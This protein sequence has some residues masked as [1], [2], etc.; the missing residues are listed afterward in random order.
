DATINPDFGQVEVDP[1]VVNL[2][3][4]ETFFSE[5]RPFFIEGQSVFSFGRGGSNN[6]WGFNWGNPNFFH[7]RRIGRAP[8]GHTPSS[9]YSHAPDGTRI[10]GAAKLTGKIGEGWNFGAIQAVTNHA[11]ADYSI[12]GEIMD[13]EVEPL[14]YYG[15]ARGQREF[16]EGKRAIGF[17]GT[18]TARQFDNDDL[19]SQINGSAFTG[20]VDGWTFLDQDRTW[21]VTGWVGGTHIKGTQERILSVQQNPQHYF[22]RP[23]FDFI[24]VDSTATS[25]SGFAGRAMLNKQRGKFSLNSAVGLI[26][27]SFDANDLGFQFQTNV[28]NAHVVG[29][30]RWTEPKGI[31]RRISVNSALFNSWDFDGNPTWRGWFTN[32]S[33]TFKNYYSLFVGGAVNPSSIS[34]RRSRGGPLMKNLP[35][36]EVFGGIESDSR[37]RLVVELFGFT[38]QTASG[39][40]MNVSTELEWKPAPNISLEIEP[41]YGRSSSKAQWI[42]AFD[43]ATDL[44]TFGRRYVFAELS[45]TTVSSNIRLNWT[46]SPSLSLQLFAQ[47]LIASGEYTNFK[48]LERPKS[49]DFVTFGEGESTFDSETLIADPDGAGPAPQIELSNPDFNFKSLRGTAV[50]RW[51][52]RPG[53]RLFLVWTQSRDHFEDNGRLRFGRSFDRLVDAKADNIFVVKFTYWLNR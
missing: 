50:V 14:A 32:S 3:D 15:I 4:R 29:G 5:K 53:S 48:Y 26:S 45:Q 41:E 19:R 31:Y 51:E 30:Y 33:T 10:L 6:N 22:Q 7:S 12:D 43:D 47:P 18:T 44:Q 38:Y 16:G 35:G 1:A 46:F 21:V 49:Y 39:D 27:P 28:I 11:M 34:N 25:L 23:D 17:L 9:D 36:V 37:K 13:I 40:D 8:Q 42:G 20:G 52:F 2:S 24:S